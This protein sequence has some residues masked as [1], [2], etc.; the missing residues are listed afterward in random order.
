M[1]LDYSK[2]QLIAVSVDRK[3]SKIGYTL[4]NIVL[5]CYGLNAFKFSYTEED[6]FKFLDLIKKNYESKY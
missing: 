1:S 2:N 5:C 6:T 3:N 4:N